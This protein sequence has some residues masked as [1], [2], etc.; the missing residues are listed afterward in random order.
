MYAVYTNVSIILSAALLQHQFIPHTIVH[1][2][3]VMSRWTSLETLFLIAI[4]D[5][6]MGG[7]ITRYV[8]LRAL[9]TNIHTD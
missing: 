7:S 8:K 2:A 6:P 3:M 1:K 9:R 5:I 4:Y